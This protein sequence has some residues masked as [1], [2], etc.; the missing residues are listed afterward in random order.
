MML[1]ITDPISCCTPVMPTLA[2]CSTTKPALASLS[3]LMK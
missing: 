2:D 3:G 1:R